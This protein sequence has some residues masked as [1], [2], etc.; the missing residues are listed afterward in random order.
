[1]SFDREASLDHEFRPLQD[2]IGIAPSAHRI[3]N[4]QEC[5]GALL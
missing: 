3:A 1:L 4:G 5:N 2:G